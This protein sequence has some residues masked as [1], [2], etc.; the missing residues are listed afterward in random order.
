M[1]DHAKPLY[2][3]DQSWRLQ[4]STAVPFKVFSKLQTG[5]GCYDHCKS[6]IDDF[7]IL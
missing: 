5:Y 6:V 2:E 7:K 4:V 1:T 3:L